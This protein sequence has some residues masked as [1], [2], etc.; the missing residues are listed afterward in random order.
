MNNEALFDKLK[1][2]MQ[3]QT[4]EVLNKMDEKL[5]PFT[6]EI[7]ELRLENKILKEKIANLEKNSRSNNIIIYGLKETESSQ[8]DLLEKVTQKLTTHLNITV[9]PKDVNKIYRIGKKDTVGGKTRPIL[10]ACVNGWL[11]NTIMKNKKKLG[12]VYVSED[13]PKEVLQKRREL[14]ERVKEERDKGNYATI[15]YDKLIIKDYSTQ[16]NNRKR[17]LSISP[18]T[19]IQPEKNVP[20]KNKKNAFTLMR[21]RS[22]STTSLTGKVEHNA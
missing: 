4:K 9:E 22:N 5:A 20:T 1:T 15:N 19:P 3:N 14:H 21:G 11:K 17:D 16:T 12:D 8:T 6:R 13:F 10:M 18:T 7:E 2:E